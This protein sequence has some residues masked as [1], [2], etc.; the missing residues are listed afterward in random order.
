MRR[1]RSSAAGS[2]FDKLP[3]RWMLGGGWD[4]DRALGG[5]LPTAV[6]DKLRSARA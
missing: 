4:H 5:K 3:R 6:I 1:T 2:E